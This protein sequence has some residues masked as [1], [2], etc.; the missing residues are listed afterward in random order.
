MKRSMYV[1][2]TLAALLAAAR[3]DAGPWTMLEGEAAVSLSR[4]NGEFD[5]YYN[6]DKKEHKLPGKVNTQDNILSLAYGVYEDWETELRLTSF[7]YSSHFSGPGETQSGTGDGWLSV[8]RLFYRGP[9]DLAFKAGIKW[10]GSYEA[11]H[12]TSPGDG[13]ADAELRL[14]AGRYWSRFYVSADLAYRF[15]DGP[16]PDEYEVFVDMGYSLSRL[17]SLRAFSRFVDASS[18]KGSIGD[19][20]VVF[21]ETEEDI[22]SVGGEVIIVPA[23]DISL[24][25]QYVKTVDGRNTPIRSDIGFT[26][27]YYIDFLI[28]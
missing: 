3:A 22:L 27:T 24:S 8:K 2:L 23:R 7:E 26:L 28:D 20:G 9:V 17:F 16:P 10:P 21:T 1:L 12:V 11:G 13:Q 6:L 4:I 14:L 15:R 25:A 18:G 5:S 19:K